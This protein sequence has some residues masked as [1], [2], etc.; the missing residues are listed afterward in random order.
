MDPVRWGVLG[1]ARIATEKVIPAMQAG[2]RC[3]IDAIASRDPA[4]A[5]NA[6]AE[7]GIARSHGSY[8]AMIDDPDIDAIYNPLPNHLHVP[9]TIRAL[10]AGKHVLCEKPVALTAAEAAPL[11]AARDRS[12]RQVQE[13]FMVRHHPQWRK[14]RE[15]LD[16]GRLGRV[17]AVQGTFAYDNPDPQN[18]RNRVETGG[19][20]IYDIGCYP[21]VI[22]RFVFAA[23]PIRAVALLER[24]P[25]FGTDRLASAILAF[26]GGHASFTCSTQVARHQSLVVLG[27]EAWLRV[28]FP[29]VMEPTRPCRLF[30]G[31]G[32]FPG[33]VPDETIEIPPVDHYTCQGDAVSA[34]LQEGRPVPYPIEDAIANM[35]VL[36]ALFASARK[37]DWQT[38]ASG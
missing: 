34:C 33:P 21:T 24:D 27:T 36:D 19:G 35:R 2:Q 12:G 23:E 26:P 11:I 7:L 3:R 28:E 30:L 1:V 17:R 5:A 6:A 13:A 10:D 20:G 16:S 9:W 18:I 32:A 38:V 14:V 15:L 4:R 29:F 8:Q 25:A 22:S 37:G 31:G